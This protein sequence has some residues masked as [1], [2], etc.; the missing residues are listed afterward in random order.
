MGNPKTTSFNVVQIS[1]WTLSDF[2]KWWKLHSYDGDAEEWYYT[3]TGKKKK[4]EKE[5]K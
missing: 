1:G 5:N 2:K 4:V 3:I